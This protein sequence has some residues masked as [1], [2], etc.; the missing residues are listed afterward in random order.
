MLWDAERTVSVLLG[1]RGPL[2]IA[3]ALEVLGGSV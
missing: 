1:C 2:R 3:S